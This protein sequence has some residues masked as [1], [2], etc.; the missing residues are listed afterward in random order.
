M[1][2]TF[3][4]AIELPSLTPTIHILPKKDDNAALNNEQAQQNRW[5]KEPQKGGLVAAI[6]VVIKNEAFV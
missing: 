3:T 2:T 6:C 4:A 1:A 5:P